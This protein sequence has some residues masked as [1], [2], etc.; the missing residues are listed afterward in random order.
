MHRK[1]RIRF[2]A[3]VKLAKV[4]Q[5]EKVLDLG[6]RGQVLRDYL[7]PVRY[8]GVDIN[9]I[10]GQDTIPWNLKKGLPPKFSIIISTPSHNVYTKKMD[11]GHIHCFRPKNID[12]LARECGLLCESYC[13]TSITIPGIKVVLPMFHAWYTDNIVYRMVPD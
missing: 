6:C 1:D 11:P 13:G 10:T 4:Q 7:P 3:V 12:N 2:E 8:V 5:G 9:P